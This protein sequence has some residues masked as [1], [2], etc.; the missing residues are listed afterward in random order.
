MG[1]SLYRQAP[2]RNTT[3]SRIIKFLIFLIAPG[4]GIFGTFVFTSFSERE[5]PSVSPADQKT[6]V[7]PVQAVAA[8]GRLSPAGDIRRLAAPVSG[9]GGTPRVAKLFVAEGD[10]V[11]SGQ[12]LAVFDNRPQILADLSVLE[13]RLKTLEI[14]IR[15]Q[16]REVSRYKKAA[17]QGAAAIVVL[18]EK[19]DELVR[20][21]GQR[22]ESFAEK[23]GLSAD[24]NDSELRSPIDG[25]ILRIYSRPGERPGNDGVLEVGANQNM[26][27]LIE[28]YESDI[29]RVMIGQPVSLI[30][31][32]GGFE[33]TLRGFVQRI[34][35]QVRQR[36]VLSTDPTGDADARVIEVRV[37]LDQAS[38]SLVRQLTG[39]KVIARFQPS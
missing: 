14:K 23:L 39:M 1:R 34:S 19:E 17:V 16:K 22:E 12:V 7:R 27:A 31:E 29:N 8:L 38:A 37:K 11:K 25:V 26:E 5:K 13:A 28:V 24:L 6:F 35:P 33:G 32:N 4:I 21:S 20:L 2:V 9:F 15:M 30:S 10:V 3:T 18:E 36:N